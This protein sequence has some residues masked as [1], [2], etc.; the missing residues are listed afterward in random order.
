M[1]SDQKI[2]TIATAWFSASSIPAAANR[3][4][5]GSVGS[6]PWRP[7]SVWRRHRCDSIAADPPGAIGIGPHVPQQPSAKPAKDFEMALME[8]VTA[9]LTRQAEAARAEREEKQAAAT[10]KYREIIRRADSPTKDDLPN[11]LAAMETLGLSRRDLAADVDAIRRDQDLAAR[12]SV[13]RAEKAPL[14]ARARQRGITSDG[15]E[16]QSAATKIGMELSEIITQRQRLQRG[17]PRVFG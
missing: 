16:A 10:L 6:W 2:V 5:L 9:H 15:P 4:P 1:S 17:N 11:I 7:A 3:S 14:D 8:Q 12:A 13:L